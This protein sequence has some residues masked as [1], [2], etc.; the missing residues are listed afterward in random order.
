MR[1]I[2]RAGRDELTVADGVLRVKLKAAPVDGAANA[3]L[4][5]LLAEYLHVT[6]AAITITRGASSRSKLVAVAG[7]SSDTLWQRLTTTS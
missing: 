3:A 5:A 6:K 2:P 1:V 4:I 7:L